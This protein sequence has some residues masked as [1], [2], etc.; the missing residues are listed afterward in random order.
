MADCNVLSDTFSD[1]ATGTN[2]KL[3]DATFTTTYQTTS[4]F[5]SGQ[6]LI[7]KMTAI[8][9]VQDQ[10]SGINPTLLLVFGVGADNVTPYVGKS[11]AVKGFNQ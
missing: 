4:N 8:Q 7:T 10:T 5:L 9:L 11:P 1:V 3:M 2:L 6:S